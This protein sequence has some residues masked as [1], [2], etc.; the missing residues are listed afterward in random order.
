MRMVVDSNYLRSPQLRDW[1]SES[2]KNIV[3]LTDQTELEMVK[4]GTLEVILRSTEV[5]VDFPLQVVLAKDIS[6]ASGLRGKRRRMKKRLVDG[7]RTRAFR[8]WC[9]QR[10]AIKSSEKHY[11][12]EKSHE[13]AKLHMEDVL[14]GAE[15]FKEDLAKH[16]ATH[17]T[18]EELA[19]IRKGEKWNDAITK[20]VIDG[21]MDF[22]LKFYALHPRWQKLPESRE[23]PHTFV[24]RYALC[25]YLHALH[26]IHIGGVQ[27]RKQE[28]LGNDLV[29][30]GFIAYAT[31][32]DGLLT[33]DKLAAAIYKNARYLLDQGF[34]R[35]DLM[36]K[37][38]KKRA[39]YAARPA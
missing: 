6:V 2:T 26:W 16:A 32:F 13:N 39:G 4:A 22:A 7:K 25:A 27:D 23:I 15:N 14:K 8:K 11:N 30:I 28:K 36:P 17:Y 29:D 1:L 9:A 20:K 35:E 19:T 34:L 3:A 24:F 10:E 38:E 33:N 12:L 5:L 37:H 21:I 31:F 18:S